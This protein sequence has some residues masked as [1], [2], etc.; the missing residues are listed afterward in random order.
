MYHFAGSKISG[1]IYLEVTSELLGKSL[2]L[3]FKGYEDVEFGT[4]TKYCGRAQVISMKYTIA[5]WTQG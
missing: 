5:K 1:T 4:K 3:Y 2:M